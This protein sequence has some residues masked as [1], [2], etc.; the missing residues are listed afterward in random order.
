MTQDLPTL[1]GD[2]LEAN[3][4]RLYVCDSHRPIRLEN[5]YA[6]ENEEE[7]SRFFVFTDAM[8][9]SED[10]P[11]ADLI[12]ADEEDSDEESEQES[13]IEEEEDHDDM[14]G[15]AELGGFNMNGNA[16]DGSSPSSNNSGTK[17]KRASEDDGDEN[18]AS[19]QLN[20][21]ERES[22]HAQKK[23]YESREERRARKAKEKEARRQQKLEERQAK[24][25]EREEALAKYYR[26]SF[27]SLPASYVM[28]Q[29]AQQLS[30][31]QNDLLWLAI[32]G[33]T[34]HYIHE[35]MSQDVYQELVQVYQSEVLSLNQE[36]TNNGGSGAGNTRYVPEKYFFY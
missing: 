25:S 16:Q 28:Y 19:S 15:E 3:D 2:M 9:N 13:E 23:P 5:I 14:D 29:L 20:S 6:E 32:V 33:L 18:T 26:G 8:A 35:R 27:Y 24:L 10:I 12:F 34:D 21:Q 1:Y 30:R 4:Q 17:R 7:E 22:S 36:D 11:S 31:A